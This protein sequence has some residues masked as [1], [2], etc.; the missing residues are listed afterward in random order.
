M[1][2]SGL[3]RIYLFQY[4]SFGCAV[5]HGSEVADAAAIKKKEKRSDQLGVS[6]HIVMRLR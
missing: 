3:K 4:H 6:R 5:L 2:C 1:E